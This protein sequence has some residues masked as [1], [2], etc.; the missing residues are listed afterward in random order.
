MTVQ[1]FVL[2]PQLEADTMF[3]ADWAL[4]RVLLMNDARFPWLIFVPRRPALCELHDLSHAERMALIEEL[5]RA[6][7]NL[8]ALTQAA[9]I[10]TAALGNQVPQ[11]HVHVVARHASDAAWPDPVWG[12]GAAVPYTDEQREGLLDRLRKSL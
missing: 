11:L 1:P 8:K 2:H 3:V 5:A 4:S 7:K 10:N 12:G 9:K 6:G